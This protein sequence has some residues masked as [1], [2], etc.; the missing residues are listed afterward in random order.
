MGYVASAPPDELFH[1]THPRAVEAIL[2]DGLRAMSR[3]YV[4]L[5]PDVET[6]TT[7]GARR[8]RPVILRVAAGELHRGGH[9]FYRAENGVW[10]TAF[11]PP[12]AVSRHAVAR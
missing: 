2:R 7:V 3:Q 1:G 9:A 4:H 6:A 8:G 12:E 5:S 11:V 10:L